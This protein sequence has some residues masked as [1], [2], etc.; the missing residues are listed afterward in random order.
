MILSKL[1]NS[2]IPIFA[3]FFLGI[4]LRTIFLVQVPPGMA[5]D[6]I[7]IIINAQSLLHTG[8]NIPGVVTGILGKTSGNLGGGIHSEI[9]SWLI[10]PFIAVFGFSWPIVKLPFVFASLGVVYVS[11]LLV[12]KLIGREAGLI[13]AFL[14]AINPWSIFFA[15]SGY[16]SIFSAF[17]YLLAI[18]V[19]FS[20]KAWKILWATPLFLAGLL[21]YFSAKTI[22][23][24]LALFTLA[25]ARFTN[26]KGSVKPALLVSFL[27]LIFLTIYLPLLSKSPAGVRFREL[28]DQNIQGIVNL[29]RTQ[30]LNFPLVEI[31]ENKYIEEIRHRTRA[32]LGALSANFLFQDGQP[33]SIPSLAISDHAPLYLIDLPLIVF[34]LVFLARTNPG[35]LF[36]FLGFLVITLIPNFLNL[37]GTTYTIRTVILF[38]ILTLISAIGIYYLK[39][40]FSPQRNLTYVAVFAVY[41]LFVG[42]FAIQYFSR[43]PVDRNE[44]WFLPDRVV[45][46][47]IK[48]SF[49]KNIG[50]ITLVSAT[51]KQTAYRY[52]LFNKLYNDTQSIKTTNARFSQ[53][54][55][56]IGNLNIL[57]NCPDFTVN[58]NL[59]V[60]TRIPCF[61]ELRGSSIASIKDGRALY[62]ITNDELCRNYVSRHYPLIKDIAYLDIEN[63]SIED[64]CQN[65]LTDIK[66]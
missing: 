46:K 58:T 43:L 25:G 2:K 55:Y 47:Y 38:P 21:S 63:L 5:N 49:D 9:S 35:L 52:L 13:A 51:P 62:V 39:S 33:E 42:N 30:S 61:Q 44:G 57:G 66:Y 45:A 12:K 32:A 64:F 41:L 11:Y 28:N 19:I 3:I 10:V 22:M 59:I 15:R 36:T 50:D 27:L 7:N 40:S 31:Y 48:S 14:A 8:Q 60:D 65:F 24:P 54:D 34:G 18:Y 37:Q 17:F 16:E 4:L 6:E 26:P 20:F 56:R 1:F 23:L 29:K 53:E